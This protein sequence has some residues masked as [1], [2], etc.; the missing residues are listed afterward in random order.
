[1]RLSLP[2]SAGWHHAP[3]RRSRNADSTTPDLAAGRR[4]LHGS[5]AAGLALGPST[6]WVPPSNR[7]P[8]T[9]TIGV[10][11]AKVPSVR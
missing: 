5:L 4:G 8:G 1:M 10:R 2:A 6:T 7:H 9:L 11:T 3:P